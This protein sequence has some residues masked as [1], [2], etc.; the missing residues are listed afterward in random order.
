VSMRSLSPLN[1]RNPVAAP[2][3]AVAKFPGLT[4]A[5]QPGL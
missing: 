2:K 5:G 4:V 3:T 1:E